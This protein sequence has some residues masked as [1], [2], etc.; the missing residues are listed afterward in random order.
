V[1]PPSPRRPQRRT[2]AE[3]NPCLFHRGFTVY[4]RKI[5]TRTPLLGCLTEDAFVCLTL[6]YLNSEFCPA[7]L[8]RRVTSRLWRG[9]SPLALRG[10]QKAGIWTATITRYALC[11]AS[12]PPYL[13]L[14]P[15]L[16][17]PFLLLSSVDRPGLAAS[18]QAHLYARRIQEIHSRT[19]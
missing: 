2:M 7:T 15:I 18:V 13:N 1:T 16:T 12:P 17:R 6:N 14:Y 4:S 9:L 8:K 3:I 10:Y 19:K 5:C 11:C